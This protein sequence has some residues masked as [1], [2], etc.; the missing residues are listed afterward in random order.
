M[1]K[2]KSRS[3]RLQEALATVSI[4]RADIEALRDELQSWLDNMPEN[5]QQSSKAG[6]LQEAIDQLETI[7]EQLEEAEGT[8][9]M[10]PGMY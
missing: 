7:I 5:L 1:P 6:E 3:E 9:V 8:E 4:G 2:V 10:F